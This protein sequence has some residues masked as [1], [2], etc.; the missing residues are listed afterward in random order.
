MRSEDPGVGLTYV[1]S[2][3]RAIGENEECRR[4]PADPI[5]VTDPSVTIEKNRR[6][7]LQL[8]DELR[9]GLVIIPL[10]DQQDDHPWMLGG[11]SLDQRHLPSAGDAVGRPEVDQN[12]P[13]SLVGEA[14]ALTV[15]SVECERRHGPAA[16]RGR[17]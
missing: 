13:A 4:Q 17:T 14:D 7:D 12:R 11:R 2:L 1:S 15:E 9:R 5:R 3:D 10:V 6:F 8:G 16:R